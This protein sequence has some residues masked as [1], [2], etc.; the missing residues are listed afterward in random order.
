MGFFDKLNQIA[1]AAGDKISGAFTN[2][3]KQFV[4]N[5]IPTSLDQLK[6]LKEADMK[7][8]FGVAALT[9]LALCVYPEDKETCFQM[10]DY[11]NGP[12]TVSERLKQFMRDRFMDGNDYVP[13][14]YLKGATPDNN[15]TPSSPYTVVVSSGAHS[16]DQLNE[17][18][19]VLF[20][21][22][23][24]ADSPRMIKLRNKPSTGEWFIWDFE[25]AL[26]SIRAPKKDNPWA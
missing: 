15:Y 19:M 20:L 16:K 25:G 17:G 7:D 10:L 3:N 6:A 9:V 21:T 26:A 8:P 11:L 13:R 2:E 12:E 23:G 24:G 4:F 22:S 18:Y 14:S 5:D 1:D